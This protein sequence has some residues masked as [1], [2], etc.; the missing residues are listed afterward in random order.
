[1]TV[2]VAMNRDGNSLV[3]TGTADLLQT[4]FGMTP[5]SVMGG[6]LRVEDKVRVRF[7]IV[8]AKD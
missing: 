6:G 2:P 1:M 7:H 5:F 8:A 4:D 3:V